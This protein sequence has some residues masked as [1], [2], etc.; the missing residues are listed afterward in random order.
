MFGL[1][2]YA[3]RDLAILSWESRIPRPPMAIQRVH[4]RISCSAPLIPTPVPLAGANILFAIMFFKM[5]LHVP[6]AFDYFLASRALVRYW[7][8]LDWAGIGG[9]FRRTCEADDM[10]VV[11]R[12]ITLGRCARYVR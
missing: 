10:V 12:L 5:A 3:Q 6:H 1:A 8:I 4:P 11:P 2:P 9:Q 7:F